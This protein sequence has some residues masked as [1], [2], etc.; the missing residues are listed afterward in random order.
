MAVFKYLAFALSISPLL[1]SAE[2]CT[3]ESLTAARDAFFK[4]APSAPG[5]LAANVKVAL[6]NKPTPLDQTPYTKIPT[7]TWT[8]LQAQAVDTEICEIATFKVATQQLLSTRL[9]LDASGA[10]SEIEF[11]QA[12][13]GDQFFRPTGFPKTTPPMFDQK[14]TPAPP[15]TIPAEFTPSMGMFDH[16]AAV[17]ASTCKALSGTPRLWTR[18]ELLYAASSYCDGLKGKPFDSCVFAGKSCP[19]NENG[20]TTTQNCGVGTGVFGFTV[21]G[22]RWTVDTETGVV[23]GAFYFD[24]GSGSNLFLHEYFKVQAGTLAYILAPMKNIP[25]AQAALN[26]FSQAA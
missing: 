14:Q 18:K 5:N 23:L 1:A 2:G 17:S 20:V 11:L 12:V 9:K 3:R 25:H 21:R 22:R 4:G 24:Y 19:R 16:K 13:Q 6:N 26:T 15:P 7:S 8:Q 10:I